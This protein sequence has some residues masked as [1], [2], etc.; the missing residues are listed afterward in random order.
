ML[1]SLWVQDNTG[2]I[3]VQPLTQQRV[4]T[5]PFFGDVE[6]NYIVSGTGVMTIVVDNKSYTV[7]YDHPN[8]MAIKECVVN[9]DESKIEEL[10]DIPSAIE[11]YA[12]GKVTVTD[13]VL[14]Y[15]GEEIHN[16][17]TDR[18]MGM[19]R[20]GFPF[21]PMIKFLANVLEN[22]S[23]RAVQ[24][25]YTFLEHKN[26]PITEDG[27]FLAYKAVT[28]DYKDKWTG[29][30]DNS[31]GQTVSMQRRKV[32]DDCGV[33][34]SDGLHCGALEYVESYRAEHAGDRVVIVKVNPKDV[35][36]VPTDCECQKVR[37]CEYH[38]IADYEGPL[39]SLL[40][41]SE[42]GDAWT[43]EQFADFM[44]TLMSQDNDSD[45][46]YDFDSEDEGWKNN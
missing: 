43:P 28:D 40:H 17:L 29:E 42:D 34:C 37:T 16:S 44:H 30:I 25:L 14:R 7:G 6:M 24:E 12:E 35:V 20:T 31:V 36:S 19:M 26:L 38:V 4:D 13:G 32:N 3:P 1:T 18:I 22:H 45:S 23:N 9:N 39:K 11:D 15:D 5:V 10:I 46:D 27:C 8:Y 21:E 2:S 33:G 41:S